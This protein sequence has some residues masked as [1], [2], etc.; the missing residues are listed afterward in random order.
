MCTQDLEP[1]GL[2]PYQHESP[3]IFFYIVSSR[4]YVSYDGS[5]IGDSNKVTSKFRN[6]LTCMVPLDCKQ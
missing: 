2:I 5:Y 6:H 1:F 3:S 4:K